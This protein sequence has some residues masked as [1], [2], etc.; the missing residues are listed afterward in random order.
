MLAT[1][2]VQ[3][4]SG[5]IIAAPVA[6]GLATPVLEVRIA[7]LYDGVVISW[8]PA[9]EVERLGALLYQAQRL[10]RIGGW[11]ENLLTGEVLW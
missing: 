4:T 10:G 8:R 1:G 7:R 9:G 5:E 3:Y 2:K 11:E 6:G